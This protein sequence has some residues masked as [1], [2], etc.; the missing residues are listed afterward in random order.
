M[1]VRGEMQVAVSAVIELT[2]NEMRV[3]EYIAGFDAELFRQHF[4]RQ[5]SLADLQQAF[6]D[7]R[8]TLKKTLTTASRTR[9]YVNRGAPYLPL[10]VPAIEADRDTNL[11]NHNES[12]CGR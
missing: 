5:I 1:K 6:R 7:L 10:G 8:G 4:G 12:D 3:L 9:D 2:E 11:V